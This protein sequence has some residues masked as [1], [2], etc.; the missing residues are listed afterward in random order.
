MVKDFPEQ[1]DNYTSIV[2]A[3]TMATGDY[4]LVRQAY[5]NRNYGMKWILSLKQAD[6]II[7]TLLEITDSADFKSP[8]RPKLL[9]ELDK[10]EER[11]EDAI[12][13]SQGTFQFFSREDKCLYGPLK[14]DN[15]EI[16]HIWFVKPK[17]N[18]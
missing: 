3:I 12:I 1:Y 6:R 8:Y 11:C 17:E 7:S 18:N 14:S 4:E 15:V 16:S 2:A 10:L 5:Y 13:C 9:E